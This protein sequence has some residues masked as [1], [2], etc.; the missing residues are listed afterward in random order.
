MQVL[1]IKFF[2][3][4]LVGA[5]DGRTDDWMDTTKLL[6]VFATMVTRLPT[7]VASGWGSKNI[8]EQ[9]LFCTVVKKIKRFCLSCQV[10]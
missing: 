2:E 9:C 3:I 1:N 7:K 8:L 5:A 4:G 10:I 6:G